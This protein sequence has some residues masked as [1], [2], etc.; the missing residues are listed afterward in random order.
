MSVKPI[1]RRT[2]LKTLPVAAGGCAML[3]AC[4]VEPMGNVPDLAMHHDMKPAGDMELTP[5]MSGPE[6][7]VATYASYP[8]LQTPG[9]GVT[10]YS[11][12]N[13]PVVIVRTG[14]N[15]VVALTAICTHLGCTVAYNMAANNI[16]CPCHGSQYALTGQVTMGPATMPLKMYTAVIGPNAI[17]VTLA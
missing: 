10:A 11:P 2:V 7:L 14:T 12:T 15:T 6:M 17:T 8:A 9:H 16:K 1:D 5:D 3:G 4:G 13:K